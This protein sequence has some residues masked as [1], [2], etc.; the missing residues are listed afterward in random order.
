MQV[1]VE[2]NPKHWTA[3]QKKAGREKTNAETLIETKISQYGDDVVR[4]I[5]E[6]V[7]SKLRKR[8][9]ALDEVAIEALLKQI[10]T[11]G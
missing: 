10:E 9:E 7:K 6:D 5:G 4:E 2:I 11:G 8:V 3:I 1:T